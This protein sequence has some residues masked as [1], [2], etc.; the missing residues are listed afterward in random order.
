VSGARRSPRVV[1]VDAVCQWM[2]S[3]LEG[4][5]LI[6]VSN[7]SLTGTTVVAVMDCSSRDRRDSPQPATIAPKRSSATRTA[8]RNSWFPGEMSHLGVDRARITMV[9]DRPPVPRVGQT[10]EVG[11]RR[12]TTAYRL[13][14][15]EL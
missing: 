14:G 7:P 11:A 9:A 3:P 6:V 12:D 1:A 15:G 10:G 4:N 2:A 13:N 8:A 5:S